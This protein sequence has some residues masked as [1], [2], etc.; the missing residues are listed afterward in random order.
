MV[1]I[2]FRGNDLAGYVAYFSFMAGDSIDV[3]TKF[4]ILVDDEYVPID[5]TGADIYM[6]IGLDTPIQLTI[7][8]GGIIV[9]DAQNGVIRIAIDSATTATWKPCDFP[10]D[11]WVEPTAGVKNE[12]MKGFFRVSRGAE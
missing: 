2:Q 11:L 10:I 12:W 3:T 5:I 1:T 6:N 9:E 7:A 8:N 4:E